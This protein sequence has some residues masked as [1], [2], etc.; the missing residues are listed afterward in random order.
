M[1]FEFVRIDNSGYEATVIRE[2]TLNA[3]MTGPGTEQDLEDA[4]AVLIKEKTVYVDNEAL[5]PIVG[6]GGLVW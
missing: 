3:D 6:S 4:G 5:T 2:V 1:R